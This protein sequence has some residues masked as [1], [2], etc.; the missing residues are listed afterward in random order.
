MVTSGRCRMLA[1]GMTVALLAFYSA[2]AAEETTV[3]K[4]GSHLVAENL[5]YSGPVVFEDGARLDIAAN[6]TVT[7]AKG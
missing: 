6:V 4:K 5:F 1:A 7:F 2:Q 3:I